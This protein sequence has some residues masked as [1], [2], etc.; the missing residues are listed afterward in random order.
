MITLD[1]PIGLDSGWLGFKLLNDSEFLQDDLV[2]RNGGYPILYSYTG[3]QLYRDETLPG[4]VELVG[5]EQLKTD[6]ALNMGTVG[7]PLFIKLGTND[8]RVVGV[9]SHGDYNYKTY[10]TRISVTKFSQI[11]LWMMEDLINAY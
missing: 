6:L 2:L 10:G 8:Y 1:K 3:G 11:T 9:M 4:A 7:S 5:S